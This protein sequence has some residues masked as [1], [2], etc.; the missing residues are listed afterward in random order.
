MSLVDAFYL[1]TTNKIIFKS[2]EKYNYK[3]F[4]LG[5]KN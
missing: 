3:A 5:V 1:V 2:Y 4:I